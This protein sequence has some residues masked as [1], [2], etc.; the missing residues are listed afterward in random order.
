MVRVRH[1]DSGDL[2][3]RRTQ[4]S[5]WLIKQLCY[6]ANCTT[7]VSHI[8]WP[9]VYGRLLHNRHCCVTCGIGTHVQEMAVCCWRLTW[10]RRSL[11]GQS[12]PAHPARR[13]QQQQPGSSSNAELAAPDWAA[14]HAADS[15]THR[16]TTAAHKLP[17]GMHITVVWQTYVAA[18][19]SYTVCTPSTDTATCCVKLR[20]AGCSVH[21]AAAHL[22]ALV[23][24]L[25]DQG[26]GV[27]RVT[28]EVVKLHLQVGW[29]RTHISGNSTAVADQSIKQA[30]KKQL[31]HH[32][33]MRSRWQHAHNCTLQENT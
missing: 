7:C 3:H 13:Q 12:H 26:I 32:G 18:G 31:H 29:W 16:C 15:R 6:S 8:D 20:G 28:L 5:Y 23:A 11:R 19:D 17:Y 21:A 4:R 24:P 25:H 30:S 1:G 27:S 9:G 10:V 22:Q 2:A 14:G 33:C